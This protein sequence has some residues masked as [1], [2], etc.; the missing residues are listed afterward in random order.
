M[1]AV[2]GRGEALSK[3]S[4]SE[5]IKL[6]LLGELS[7]ERQNWL[8]ERYFADSDFFDQ[9]E[10]VEDDLIHQYLLG[11]LPRDEQSRLEELFLVN[12]RAHQKLMVIAAIHRQ[13][14]GDEERPEPYDEGIRK[15]APLRGWLN[16]LRS[17]RRETK[18]GALTGLF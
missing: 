10:V 5:E 16:Q 9:I 15:F 18:P 7:E 6:Y 11:T 4:E 2:I 8:E 17:W 13:L 1:K 12:S 3:G 14:S